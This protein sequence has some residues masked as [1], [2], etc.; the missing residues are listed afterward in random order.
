MDLNFLAG[1]H[2]DLNANIQY[3]TDLETAIAEAFGDALV[4]MDDLEWKASEHEYIT[5]ER[6]DRHGEMEWVRDA[7]HD[8]GSGNVKLS[9]QMRRTTVGEVQAK[10]GD[11]VLFKNGVGIVA[12]ADENLVIIVDPKTNKDINVHPKKLTN[13]R[14]IGNV[15]AFEYA[16]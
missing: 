3:Q 15:T 4:S 11:K 5:E 13:P 9:D 12:D 10:K 1:I 14:K 2:N 7:G 8:V 16:G 6:G